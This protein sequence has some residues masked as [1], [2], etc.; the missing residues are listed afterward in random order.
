MVLAL[1]LLGYI[2]KIIH[3][4]IQPL[5]KYFFPITWGTHLCVQLG[6]YYFFN[7]Y[8]KYNFSLTIAA[9]CH[10]IS[11]SFAQSLISKLCPD[12]PEIQ[13]AFYACM[14]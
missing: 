14:W 9:I 1:I 4:R 3:Q 12:E 13:G 7:L 11:N 2:V 10:V 6:V 5:G 8:E